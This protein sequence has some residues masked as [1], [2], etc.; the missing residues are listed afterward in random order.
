MESVNQKIQNLRKKLLKLQ[1]TYHTKNESEV[2]DEEYDNLLVELRR[3]ELSY[4][5]FSIKHSPIYNVGSDPTDGFRK[6]RHQIPMLSLNSITDKSQLFLFD[7]RIKN[8]LGGV[9]KMTYCCELKID[10]IAVSLLYKKGKLIQA[11]TRGNGK[12]GEDVTKNAYT[13]ASIPMYLKS[14]NC[15]KLPYLLEVRGEVFILKNCF[16]RLNQFMLKKKNK[17]FSNSRNAASGSLRQLNANVTASRPLNFC[18]YSISH[19]I[20]EDLLPNNHWKRL[21]LCHNWGITVSNY[22]QLAHNIDDILKFYDYIKRIRS[23]L[24]FNIDGVVVKVNNCVYQ[25]QLSCGIKAPHWAIAYKFPAE[26][27]ITKLNKIAFQVGRTG[28]IIPIAYI[29]PIV[30]DNV[31]IKKVNIHNISEI[32]RL[33]V[34]VGDSVLVTRSGDVIPKIVKVVSSNCKNIC[35]Y[36][37]IPQFCPICGSVLKSWKHKSLVLYCTAKLTCLGQR[38]AMLQHFASRK[39]MNIRGIGNNVINQLV[40]KSLISVPVDF[41]S[42]NKE[43]LLSLDRYGTKSIDRLL[44]SITLAKRTNLSRF[45]YA[46]GIPC[47]GEVTAHHLAVTYKNIDNLIVADL[48]SLSHVENIGPSVASNIYDFFRNAGNLKNVQDLI[49]PN[50]GIRWD[51]ID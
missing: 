30:I 6:I 25:D 20:G 8:K 36:V 17:L 37:E 14:K 19:Y 9:Q 13:I 42:L 33:N 48:Y 26:S 38:K 45:I 31:C 12:V 23:N 24:A 32:K 29:N 41:F 39:A 49:H 18:C 3:L 44:R 40:N 7:K 34:Q 27:Q 1:H 46:L 35:K 28:L 43:K 51:F 16:N 15:S 22:M 10:G 21:Q 4:P 5:N 11:A 47:V 2:S 50:I